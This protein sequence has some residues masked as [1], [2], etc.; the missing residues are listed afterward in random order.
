VMD[1]I[2]EPRSITF[3]VLD[4]DDFV[5]EPLPNHLYTRD[6]S[7]WIYGG[8]SI[9][10]MRKL[11]RMRETVHYEAV[12][13][14]H[15]LFAG[16]D[17]A[18]WSEGSVNGPATT[19]GGDMLVIGGGA[20][21]IGMSERTTAAGVERLARRLFAG[22]EVDRIVALRMPETRALM[23]LDTVMT[24]VDPETFTKYAGLGMLPAY[25]VRPGD[26]EKELDVTDHRPEDMHAAIAAALHLPE[27][28]VLTAE[29]DVHAAEREQWDDGCNTLAVSPGVVV[30]YERNVTT[31]TFLRSHGI[32]VLD[33]PGGELGRGRGGPRCMSCPI[34]RDPA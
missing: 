7:A 22:G 27:I 30:T 5:L 15:P 28:R 4:P 14:W 23:H 20:V 19:E 11:A 34:Q 9:N 17:Y 21:L 29:Q 10:S 26:N 8:V 16:A 1:R 3:H 13:R 25:T 2:P 31:N 32:E 12:Y 33:I 18:V 6:T 24:M